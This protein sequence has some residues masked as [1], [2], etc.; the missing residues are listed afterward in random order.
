MSNQKLKI[1]I[2]FL[3]LDFLC[4]FII[5]LVYVWLAKAGTIMMCGYFFWSVCLNAETLYHLAILILFISIPISFYLLGKEN[6]DV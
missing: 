4:L 1:I 5:D 2:S 6:K 3:S